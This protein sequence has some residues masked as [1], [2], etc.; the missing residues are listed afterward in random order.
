M[1]AVSSFAAARAHK[2]KYCTLKSNWIVCFAG[3]VFSASLSPVERRAL[4]KARARRV[5]RSRKVY[6]R[7]AIA[8]IAR[9]PADG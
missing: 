1:N 2:A 3:A 8:D 7:I 6:A 5:R 9:Q 4:K